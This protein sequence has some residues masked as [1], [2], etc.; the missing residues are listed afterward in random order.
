VSREYCTRVLVKFQ[1][2]YLRELPL[3]MVSTYVGQ[4][5]AENRE[6]TLGNHLI[7]QPN[8]TN[9]RIGHGLEEKERI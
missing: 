7:Y 3:N 5:R 9:S 1:V 6:S 2:G 8:N 4:G